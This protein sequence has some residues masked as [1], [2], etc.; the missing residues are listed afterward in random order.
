MKDANIPAPL[1][2]EKKTFSELGYHLSVHKTCPSLCPIFIKAVEHQ[3]GGSW[4]QSK[5][6]PFNKE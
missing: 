6:S 3:A 5:A 4:R 1:T 2:G